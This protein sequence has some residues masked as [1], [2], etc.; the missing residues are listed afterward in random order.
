MNHTSVPECDAGVLVAPVQPILKTA[1]MTMVD[2]MP[3]I[4]S[5]DADA[6]SLN[7]WQALSST[8]RPMGWIRRLASARGMNTPGETMPR[9][10]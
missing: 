7:R 5:Y 6:K 10:G 4:A 8:Q 1:V 3:L 2:S 9:R